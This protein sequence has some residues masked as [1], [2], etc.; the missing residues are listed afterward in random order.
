VTAV[1]LVHGAWHGAWC[2]EKVLPLLASAGVGARAIDLPG[3]G[4]GARPGWDVGLDD[5]AR[6]VADAARAMGKVHLVGHSMGGLVIARAA[7][8][9]TDAVSG[10]TFLAAFLPRPGDSILGL[11]QSDPGS[12]VPGVIRTDIIAGVSRVDAPRTKAVFYGDCSEADVS[13]AQAR[14]QPQPLR[15]LIDRAQ[16][17]ANGFGRVPRYYIACTEDRAVSHAFQQSMLARIPC[18]EVVTLR[19]SHSPFLSAP[20][21]TAE[22]IAR[23]A[24]GA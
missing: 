6:A 3:H 13:W 2:W 10:L 4:P 17:G 1:L 8:M 24:A 15:A 9:A 11:G 7:E 5:Y 19:T 12:G 14:L 20:K 21:E 22:A 16:V 23:F 18:R